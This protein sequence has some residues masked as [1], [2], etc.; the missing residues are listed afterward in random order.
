MF[1]NI[2]KI[3]ARERQLSRT[4]TELNNLSDRELRD[5]GI[6]RGQILEIARSVVN[7]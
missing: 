6:A 3:L 2:A 1:R 7:H 5:I 4:V